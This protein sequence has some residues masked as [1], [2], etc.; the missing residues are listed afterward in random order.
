MKKNYLLFDFDGVISNTEESNGR[1]LEKALKE[2]GIPLT[3]EDKQR[4]I[5]TSGR[6]FLDQILQKGPVPV[7]REE[8]QKTRCRIGNTYEHTDIAP[9]PGLISMLNFLKAHNVKMGIASSTSSKLILTALNRMNLTSYFDA[10]VCGDMCTE[11]KPHPQI[12]QKVMEFLDAKPEECIIIEDSTVGIEAGKRAGVCVIAY[13]GSGLEQDQSA[14]DYLAETYEI[15]K[16][17][18]KEIWKL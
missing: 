7:S 5:G 6:S 10:I 14:A 8:L 17:Q 3:A 16:H 2:Y 9:M 11:S 18:I 13:S 15:C 12:Y 1:F 4:L